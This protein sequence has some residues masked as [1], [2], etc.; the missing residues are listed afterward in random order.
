MTKKTYYSGIIQQELENGK[1]LDDIDVDLRLSVIK[2]VHAQWL[3][4]IFTTA[5]GRDV[6]FKGWKKAEISGLFSGSTVLPPDNPFEVIYD[7]D[8]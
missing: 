6:I 4:E 8:N 3:V 7:S 5:D 1:Q 2:P